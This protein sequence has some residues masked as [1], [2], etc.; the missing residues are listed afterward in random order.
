MKKW[1]NEIGNCF[2]RCEHEKIQKILQLGFPVNYN[3]I[4]KGPDGKILVAKTS[5]LHLA[6]EYGQLRLVECIIQLGADLEITDSFRRTPVLI[7][8]EMGCLE[9]LKILIEHGSNI[10]ARDYEGNTA[11]HI[12]ALEGKLHIVRYFVEELKFS[13]NVKN[14]QGFTPLQA[15]E[16]KCYTSYHEVQW[17]LDEVIHYLNS[18]MNKNS[19]NLVLFRAFPEASLPDRLNVHSECKITYQKETLAKIRGLDVQKAKIHKVRSNAELIRRSSGSRLPLRNQ[20][21]RNIEQILNQRSRMIYQKYIQNVKN[22]VPYPEIS[23]NSSS[24][25]ISRTGSDV[26]YFQNRAVYKYS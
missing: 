13:T 10:Q 22:D 14:K 19:G 25:S 5:A 21:R 3:L 2:D 6:C 18:L 9:I 23:T 8:C 7:A 4:R 1:A 12:A 24:K 15:C 26:S 20:S 16:A 17:V 11:L